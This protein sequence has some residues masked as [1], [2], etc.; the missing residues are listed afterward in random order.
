MLAVM[1]AFCSCARAE[2]T[3]PF[4]QV[5]GELEAAGISVS[6]EKYRE[7]LADYAWFTE[8]MKE[9]GFSVSDYYT[10]EFFVYRFLM[11]I[12]MGDYDEEWQWTPS[13]HEIYVFDAEFF[14]IEGMYTEFLQ[15]IQAI[16]PDAELTDVAE[17]LSGMDEALEGKRSVSFRYG[18]KPYSVT[19][20]SYGDW[21]NMVIMD[22]LNS[23]LEENGAAGRLHVISDDYDQMVFIIY[24]KADRARQLRNL[25]GTD[26][27]GRIPEDGILLEWMDQLIDLM[28]FLIRR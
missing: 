11:Y 2:N 6:D 18:G 24:G 19:L 13:S 7:I 12:G 1:L 27:G 21:L 26:D 25:M 20:D 10:K 8:K 17:D 15:G 16:L 14:N 23:V 5:R 4:P 28:T 9:I 22:F 3:D